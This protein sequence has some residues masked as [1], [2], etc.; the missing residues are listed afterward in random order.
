MQ[1]SISIQ[2]GSGLEV[3]AA[4]NNALQSIATDFA[5]ATDPATASP[6]NA[7]PYCTWIDTNSN[8]VKRRN[9]ANTSWYSVG[10]ISTDGKI[11]LFNTHGH[12]GVKNITANTTLTE[13]DCNNFIVVDSASTVTLTMPT[14]TDYMAFK[15]YNKGAG[16]V[17]LTNGTFYGATGSSTNLSLSQYQIVNLH[18]DGTNFYVI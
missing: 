4:I 3:R 13:N 2:N 7:F 11:M 8:L 17:L 6:S 12:S 15:I 18:S 14:A 5:G 1:S 9:A 16:M 10:T